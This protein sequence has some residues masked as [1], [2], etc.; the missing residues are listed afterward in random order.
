MFFLDDEMEGR[1]PEREVEREREKEMGV[2]WYGVV[3]GP[4]VPTLLYIVADDF[5]SSDISLIRD[6]KVISSDI[7]TCTQPGQEEKF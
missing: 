5:F 4:R 3:G 6:K 2:V 1:L 7:Y